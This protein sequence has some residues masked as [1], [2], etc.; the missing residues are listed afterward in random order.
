MKRS[1]QKGAALILATI[2]ALVLTIMGASLMFLSQSETWSSLNY[3][4]MTESRYGAEA[5]LHAAAN[6]LMNNYV[7]PSDT[8]TDLLTSY[9][10]AISSVTASGTPVDLLSCNASASQQ[11]RISAAGGGALVQNPASGLCLADPGDA[12]GNGTAVV[13]ASC[14]AGDPGMDWRVR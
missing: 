7:P 14:T 13:V 2:F 5:G 11:W 9:N 8:G 12:T 3:R 1:N 10:Y 6:Y 4:L